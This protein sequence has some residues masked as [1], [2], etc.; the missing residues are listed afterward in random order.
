M[1]MSTS[2]PARSWAFLAVAMLAASL[3]GAAAAA[4]VAGA[5]TPHPGDRTST[6]QVIVRWVDGS[7]GTANGA[8]TDLPSVGARPE[9]VAAVGEAAGHRATWIR[10]LAVGGDVYKY[11]AML[12]ADAMATTMVALRAEPGV[13]GAEPD[14]FLH[15]LASAP[16]DPCWRGAYPCGDGVGQW[17]LFEGTTSTTYGIDLLGAW[18]YT[19]GAGVTVAVIDTGITAHN[20][21]LGQTV[22]GYDFVSDPSLSNDG[23]GRDANPADPGDYYTDAYRFHASSWHGTHV[24]G[25]IVAVANNG[26]GIAGIAPQAK[27][28]PLRVLGTGGTGYFSDISDAIVWGSGGS[29]SGVPANPTPARVENLSLGGSYSYCPSALQAAISSAVNRRT[30]VVVAAGNSGRDAVFTTPANCAGVIAVAA[31]G[32]NG[33]RASWSNYGSTVD[34][35]APG[36]STWSTVNSG[37]MGPVGPAYAQYSGTSMASPH[38]AGVV[39]LMLAVKPLLTPSQVLSLLQSTAHPVSSCPGGCGAGIVDAAHAVAAAAGAIPNPTPTPTAS[40]TPTPAPTGTPAPTATPTP[41]GTPAPT[42]TATPAPNCTRGTPVVS[43]S[44][45]IVY[46]RRGSTARVTLAVRNADSSGCGSSTFAWSVIAS[47]TIAGFTSTVPGSVSVAPGA[48]VTVYATL[49]ATTS[50]PFASYV[51]FTY[52]ATRPATPS[53]GATIVGAAAF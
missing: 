5:D 31:T 48:T 14:A 44:T 10:T 52:R 17:D 43:T 22:G 47:P 38:V 3:L 27:V 45:P 53:T 11:D 12:S 7:G 24:T 34:I 37:T 35:A 19:R 4:G 16:N 23:N 46:L 9:R 8:A 49:S 1:P 28:E 42:P 18:D 13:A 2:R 15:A 26:V 29:V 41:T 33:A 50:V 36:V 30:V 6:D 40:P 32:R 51:Q 39:A 25:T 21:L 20:D